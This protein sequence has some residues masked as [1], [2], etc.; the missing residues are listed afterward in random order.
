MLSANV[1]VARIQLYLP[2]GQNNLLSGMNCPI[3]YS[4]AGLTEGSE[5]VRRVRSL[6]FFFSYRPRFFSSIP[7]LYVR[8]PST[9]AARRTVGETVAAMTTFIAR[10]KNLKA[11]LHEE[12]PL[13]MMPTDIKPSPEN[14]IHRSPKNKELGLSHS[15]LS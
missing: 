11:K 9:L 7:Q 2:T 14:L 8:F 15:L 5:S 4:V 12:P 3:S 13:S 10:G 1:Y 6:F